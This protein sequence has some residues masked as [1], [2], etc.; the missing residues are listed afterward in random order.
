MLVTR[1]SARAAAC[2]ALALAIAAGVSCADR[3][4]TT[5]K[6]ATSDEAASLG[7][8]AERQADKRAALLTNIPVTAPLPDGSTFSGLLTIKHIAL[9]DR[10]THTFMVDGVISYVKDGQT[11]TQAF[12]GIPMTLN[13]EN[14]AAT[15]IVQPAAMQAVCDVLFLDLG[16]LHL[17]LL[18]L[19]VDLAEVILDINAVTGAGNL[20]GN[21]L[22]GLLGLLDVAGLLGAVGQL[23]DTINAI[24]GGLGTAPG[25]GGAA[26]IPSLSPD[27]VSWYTSV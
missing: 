7:R 14:A 26:W 8:G 18:G 6:A 5:P 21:L 16:P 19:T 9:A 20:V 2:A 1:S 3:T 10:A 27:A 23:L 24:L 4:P 22:C 12:T 13:G 11:V 15:S 17:D 25:V